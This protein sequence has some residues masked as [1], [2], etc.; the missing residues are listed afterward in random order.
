MTM[1]KKAFL[2]TTKLEK[3][4]IDAYPDNICFICEV[5]ISFAGEFLMESVN[6]RKFM[7]RCPDVLADKAAS[8]IFKE[9][10]WVTRCGL[11]AG[12]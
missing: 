10:F 6:L 8:P 7:A 1:N 3:G 12:V 2:G 4:M 5:V 11:S 9:N